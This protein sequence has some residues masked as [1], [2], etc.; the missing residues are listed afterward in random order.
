[1]PIA[2]S[3][4]RLEMRH[5]EKITTYRR[6]LVQKPSFTGWA[7]QRVRGSASCFSA[8]VPF[9]SQGLK[10][11]S[12]TSCLSFR[13]SN[14]YLS[15][16]VGETNSL[17]QLTF[18]YSNFRCQCKAFRCSEIFFV[19][20]HDMEVEGVGSRKHRVASDG[21]GH[22]SSL[23]SSV[24]RGFSCRY[25]PDIF[26]CGRLIHMEWKYPCPQVFL[27]LQS[28][29]TSLVATFSS[30]NRASRMSFWWD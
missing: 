11:G 14:R 26:L 2:L 27:P 16:S 6:C 17:V 12:I 15:N 3:Q 28:L 25:L 29:T 10:P 20:W 24:Q 9:I 1:M 19:W 7:M 23:F 13:F 21:L 18:A 5:H 8:N 22:I 30:R 4:G